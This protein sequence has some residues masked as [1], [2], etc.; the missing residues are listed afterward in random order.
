MNFKR[1]IVKSG[2]SEATAKKYSGAVFG[3]ISDWAKESGLIDSTLLEISEPKLFHKLTE[4]IIH[5]PTFI[6]RNEKGNN[7]YSSALNKYY[8]Y[9]KDASVELEEDIESII[10]D[11]SSTETD[12][13]SL[14]KSRIGQGEFRKKLLSH[15]KACAVTGYKIPSMLVASH[16]KPWRDSN[17]QERL[18]KFNGLMLMPNLD[19]AFDSG[20]I[21]SNKNGEIMISE[22]FKSPELLCINPNM[23]IK[24][25]ADHFKYLGYHREI[26]FLKT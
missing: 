22:I 24:T 13:L 23:K 11:N 8:E 12:K 1:W 5:L 25:D 4:D 18:D 10:T 3:P 21:S 14:I 16:I 7:M 6:K 17:N 15:W 20:L 2:L 19:K 9:L 26:I